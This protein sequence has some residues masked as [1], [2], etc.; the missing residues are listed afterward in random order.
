LQFFSKSLQRLVVLDAPLSKKV[1]VS[2]ERKGLHENR[3]FA[4]GDILDDAAE[5]AHHLL[6]NGQDEPAVPKCDV[7]ILQK[8][9]N[10]GV[11]Q[12]AFKERFGLFAHLRKLVSKL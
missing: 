6:F 11:M 10:L 7:M 8:I 3:V 1:V 5:L 4:L 12:G 2:Y 9:L